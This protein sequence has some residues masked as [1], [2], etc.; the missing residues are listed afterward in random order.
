MKDCDSAGQENQHPS[1]GRGKI[2]DQPGPK[3]RRVV[4]R[5]VGPSTEDDCKHKDDGA[6]R[7]ENEALPIFT[8]SSTRR[9]I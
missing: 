5:Q 9:S 8:Q 6:R 7:E 2:Q 4:S 3:R 1:Y